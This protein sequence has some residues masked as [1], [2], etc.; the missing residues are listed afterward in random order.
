M[1]TEAMCKDSYKTCSVCGAVWASRSDFINDPDVVLIGYQTNF[2]DV[3]RGLFLFNHSC[4]GTLSISVEEFA[5][6]YDG[7]VFSERRTGEEDCP[8]FCLHENELRECPAQCECAYV[9]SIIKAFD[10]KTEKLEN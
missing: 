6:L 3:T 8:G 1:K 5:D 2:V 7:P 4:E 10:H 9:R